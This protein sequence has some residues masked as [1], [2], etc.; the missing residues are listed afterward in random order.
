MCAVV[1]LSLALSSGLNFFW[2]KLGHELLL[3][4]QLEEDPRVGAACSI[5]ETSPRC[6]D[7]LLALRLL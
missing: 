2:F 4:L 6:A 3:L 1:S 7:F 5:C